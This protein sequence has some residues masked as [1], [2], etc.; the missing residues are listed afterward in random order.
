MDSDEALFD[1]LVAGD[2]RAFDRLYERFAR[3]LFA[4]IRAQLRDPSEAEDVL[5]ETFM[6]V[7][8]ARG[9][10]HRIRSF[11]AWLYKVAHN[12]CMNRGRTL[13]RGSRAIA[14]AS[15]IAPAPLEPERA[16]EAA[17][18]GV[19]LKAALEKLPASLAELYRLR[20][21]GLS[22]EE[23]A[24]TL[25][26]PVGTVKSRMHEMIQRLRAELAQ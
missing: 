26:I 4:F 1:A 18:L 19:R 12:L 23:V 17:Q 24:T 9:E 5:H 2:M 10:R 7:L 8:R 13:D 6:A 21:A 3:Q 14:A 20:T 11:R 25:D 22:Y 16:L 15:G